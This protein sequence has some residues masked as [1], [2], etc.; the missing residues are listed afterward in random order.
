[1][2]KEIKYTVN[3]SEITISKDELDAKYNYISDEEFFLFATLCRDNGLIPYKDVYILK[4]KNS[5][6]AT[7]MVGKD[8]YFKIA[9]SC[10]AYDGMEDG[11][12]IIDKNG[13]RKDIEGTCYEPTDTLIGGWAR[14]YRKDRRVP[15]YSSVLISEYYGHP[16][17]LWGKM[18]SVMINKVA[19]CTALRDLFPQSFAGTYA[20]GEIDE[21]KADVEAAYKMDTKMPAEVE[22]PSSNVSVDIPQAEPQKPVVEP[23][24]AEKPKEPVNSPKKP[25]MTLEQAMEHAIQGG[26]PKM[27]GKLMIDIIKDKVTYPKGREFL[28]KYASNYGG[29]CDESDIEAAKLLLQAFPE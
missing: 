10:P 13:V 27:K 29:V 11:V 12:V 7:I 9:D 2:E 17:S 6:K 1:M 21:T 16:D 8:G 19:K 23:V 25:V 24:E 26:N 4:R 15:K 3:G 22:K 18:P 28:Q 5:T 20:E 14:A